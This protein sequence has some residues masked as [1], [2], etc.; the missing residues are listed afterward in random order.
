M[1]G[2]F[3]EELNLAIWRISQPPNLHLPILSH[4]YIFVHTKAIV[5]YEANWW[6]WSLH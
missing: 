4:S 6:V 1:A 5:H 3:G 2:K